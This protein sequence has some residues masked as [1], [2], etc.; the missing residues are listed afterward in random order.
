MHGRYL[1]S[2]L[3]ALVAPACMGR[4]AEQ[5]PMVEKRNDI[6]RFAVL[7]HCSEL[8]ACKFFFRKPQTVFIGCILDVIYR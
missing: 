4:G 2:P 8:L 3:D 7:R 5:L 6:S 1:Y